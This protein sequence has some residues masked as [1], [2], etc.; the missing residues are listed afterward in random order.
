MGSS[1]KLHS[2]AAGLKGE[3]QQALYYLFSSNHSMGISVNKKT[4]AGKNGGATYYT[5]KFY[6]PN[7]TSQHKRIVLPNLDSI[8]QVTIEHLL[9][10]AFINDYNFNEHDIMLA[11]FEQQTPGQKPSL[12]YPEK[13]S[14]KNFASALASNH[15]EVITQNL[16]YLFE[17]NN[18]KKLVKIIKYV[19]QRKSWFERSAFSTAFGNNA[20]DSIS[21]LLTFVSENKDHL[22]QQLFELLTQYDDSIIDGQY[23]NHVYIAYETGNLKLIQKYQKFLDEINCPD[24]TKRQA[25]LG[26]DSRL[27][28]AFTVAHQD[29]ATNQERIALFFQHAL[30]Y[31]PNEKYLTRALLMPSGERHDPCINLYCTDPNTFANIYAYAHTVKKFQ[32]KLSSKIVTTLL[33]AEDRD[34]LSVLSYCFKC[35]KG[36]SQAVITY[37]ESLLHNDFIGNET[38]KHL[39]RNI[40]QSINYFLHD[41]KKLDELKSAIITNIMSNINS[42]TEYDFTP[43]ITPFTELTDTESLF[44][45]IS[46]IKTTDDLLHLTQDKKTVLTEFLTEHGHQLMQHEPKNTSLLSIATNIITNSQQDIDKNELK[47]YVVIQLA[48][49]LILTYQSARK[50]SRLSFFKKA[51]IKT[52]LIK[53]IKDYVANPSRSVNELD[54]LSD[55]VKKLNSK[56]MSILFRRITKLVPPV[57]ETPST[58]IN[59]RL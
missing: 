27:Q 15:G 44:K 29:P 12:D 28:P 55:E 10:A 56:K 4:K 48:E 25:L 26:A 37:L 6:D 53:K 8:R 41:Q 7:K 32:N 9:D 2:I 24:E 54:R 14:K 58:D 11:S 19:T 23:N 50:H 22:P 36:T 34:G 1:I 46:L 45:L 3:S 30:D 39:N 20:T 47:H 33:L 59:H 13:I 51:D 43:F 49:H 35:K 52:S 42:E 21:A 17:S 18:I 38:Y 16:N 40:K 57:I 31:C 5:I